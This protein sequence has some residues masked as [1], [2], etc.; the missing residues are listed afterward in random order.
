LTIYSRRRGFLDAP[1][2]L[3]G[4]AAGNHGRAT[5]RARDGNQPNE[6]ASARKATPANRLLPMSANW[7]D[8]LPQEIAPRALA[9]QFPRI[10]NM[11][12]LQWNNRHACSGYFESL[13]SDRRGGRIGFPMA[14]REDL[15]RLREY[16]YTGSLKREL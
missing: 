5:A 8:A 9:A 4:S 16:W 12:A 2:V 13:V 15:L 10:V 11:M 3:P 14:V 1:A 7:L 6:W